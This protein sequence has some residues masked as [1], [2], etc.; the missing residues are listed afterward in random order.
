MTKTAK[1]LTRRSFTNGG[2]MGLAA[3]CLSPSSFAQGSATEGKNVSADEQLSNRKVVADF[4]AAFGKKD[5]DKI[6]SLLSDDC[7]YRVTQTRAP[8]VGKDK[9]MAQIKGIIGSATFKV[10]RTVA[11]GPLVLNERD[12]TILLPGSSTPRTIRVSAGM[13]YVSNGKIVEWT[14]YV[15]Q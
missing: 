12:D 8:I 7:T 2:L 3:L 14:D 10:L 9:V 11:L 6:A 4:C 13:F 1:Q 5:L 15:I